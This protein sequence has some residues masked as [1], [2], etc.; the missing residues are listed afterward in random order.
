MPRGLS[1]AAVRFWSLVELMWPDKVEL[2]PHQRNGNFGEVCILE[3][4][5]M[6]RQPNLPAPGLQGT[7]EGSCVIC[8]QGCDTGLQF[9]GE[10]EWLV[11]GLMHL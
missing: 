4:N 1:P 10:A 9:T 3:G 7:Y 8:L 5:S 2:I 6:Q 11:A